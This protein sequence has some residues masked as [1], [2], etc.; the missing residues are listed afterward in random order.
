MILS[1]SSKGEDS[2]VE[3]L[4]PLLRPVVSRMISGIPPIRPRRRP[5]V[6]RRIARWMLVP[7]LKSA[8]LGLTPVERNDERSGLR[9]EGRSTSKICE[10]VGSIKLVG[11]ALGV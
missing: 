10:P 9:V 11:R 2:T 6:A 5:L 7:N 8:S 1:S 4:F 3:R